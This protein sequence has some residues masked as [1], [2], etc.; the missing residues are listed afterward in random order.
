MRGLGGSGSGCRWCSAGLGQA[1]GLQPLGSP[2][3]RASWR[4]FFF[5]ARGSLGALHS[6]REPEGGAVEPASTAGQ[7]LRST[8]SRPIGAAGQKHR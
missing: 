8:A 5:N 3:T 7:L 2:L 6:S 4:C 1:L